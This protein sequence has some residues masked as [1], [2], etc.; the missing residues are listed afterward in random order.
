MTYY[1][2]YRPAS[3]CTLPAGVSWHYVTAPDYV[4]RP[5]L[6]RSSYRHGTFAT[7]RELT[8]E[9]MENY[10]IGVVP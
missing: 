3:F 8:R 7:S 5:D 9:E 4:N 1:L 10:E 2:K 6:P